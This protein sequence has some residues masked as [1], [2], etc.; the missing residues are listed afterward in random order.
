M[1]NYTNTNSNDLSDVEPLV[2]FI[3][4]GFIIFLIIY[5][6]R[7]YLYYRFTRINDSVIPINEI[8][9]T[10]AEIVDTQDVEIKIY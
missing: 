9:E 10:T 3:L 2:I 5:V 8:V 1:L 7:M 4:C 6:V